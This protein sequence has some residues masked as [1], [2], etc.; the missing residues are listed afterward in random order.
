[1]FIK[2]LGQNNYLWNELSSLVSY[3]MIVPGK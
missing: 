1:M 2:Q 3:F